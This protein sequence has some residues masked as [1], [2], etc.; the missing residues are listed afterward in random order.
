MAIRPE[1]WATVERLYHAAQALAV[2]QRA[3]FL[4]EA[5]ADQ[6]VRRE[7]ESLLAQHGSATDA[8]T[9]GAVAAA[10]AGLASDVG[11]SMVVGRRFGVYQV[12]A[13]LGAGGMGEV[14]RARDTRLGRNVAIK[15]VPHE[16]TSLPNRLARCEREARMLAALNHPHI[17]AIYGI[18]DD[19]GIHA[20]VL[21]LV[22]GETL[23]E[24]IAR[25]PLPV[26]QALE[27]ARQIADALDA[28]HEKGI[29][30][31]DL[32]PANIKI[33][34]EGIVK[35]LDFGLAKLESAGS[36]QLAAG[37]E[38][39]T[40]TV[41]AT[42]AGLIVGTAAYMSPEQARGL[43]VDKR[44]DI[45]AFGCVLY[46]MLTGRAAFARDTLADTLSAV[47]DRDPQ[48]DALPAATPSR[49]VRLL[50]RCLDKDPARRL[51]YISG[52]R[53]ELDA[54]LQ[55][56]RVPLPSRVTTAVVAASLLVLAAA[57]LWLVRPAPPTGSIAI[58]P[59]V[60]A[61]G[62]QDVDYLGDGITESLINSL[63]QVPNLAVMSRNSV[64][65]YKGRNVDAQAVGRTLD[66]QAVLT[67]TVAQRGDDLTISTELVDVRNNR[68]LWGERYNRKLLDILAV[69]EDIATEI[70]D[71]LRIKLTGEQKQRLV[72]QYTQNTDAYQLYLKGRYYW[73]KKT[74]DGFYKGIDYF[75]Q[76]IQVDPN[77]APAYA[78]MAALYINLA[79]YN[80]ALI[81]PREA[82]VKAKAAA[83]RALQI[84]DSLASAHASAA[85]VAYQ[86]EWDWDT[87][88]REFQR[89]IQL[90]PASSSTYEPTPASTY[91]W[92]AHYLMTMRQTEASSRAWRRALEMD[93]LDLANNAHQGWHSLFLRRYDESV[94]L[95][96]NAIELDPTFPVPQW[97]L[98]LAYEQ[99]GAFEAAIRQFET[100][101]RLT[102]GRPSMLAL[103]GHAYAAAGQ[104]RQAQA[105]L[106]QLAAAS[107]HSYVPN[108]PVAVIQAALGQT[109]D[110]FASLEKAYDDR[111]SWMDYVALDPRLDSLRSDSRFADLLRRMNLRP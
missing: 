59:F 3:P 5:C 87:A 53:V 51:P 107:A 82:A 42:H 58:L 73:N 105:I 80:F 54:A 23:A 14:Y 47:L 13:P 44:T 76:A 28:A 45:W 40:V 43:P 36:G 33:T 25:G 56:A 2:E 74:A 31:R 4:A 50:R 27:I 88:E 18:E 57:G 38:S 35:V 48:W 93:P 77:Y 37:S 83:T 29:V 90:E 55:P 22:D 65:R 12:L 49:V 104:R 26:A 89:A 75:Q 64:F 66:V 46:E 24:R 30:H 6:T 70:S 32:K 71:R 101:V 9:R 92:Y 96:K 97:Y 81:P 86:W 91:H 103:L 11:R 39:P 21:E 109:D 63:S 15:I 60:N 100:C 84:D 98:G 7:V 8:L 110:A 72:K 69:Q 99:Q 52:A 67:G 94:E 61:S 19:E 79:N 1:L 111:D 85:L 16:F 108:Y 10:A 20:L 17:A 78:G 34:P 68:H 95:L 62:N 41:N 102:G 106:Q